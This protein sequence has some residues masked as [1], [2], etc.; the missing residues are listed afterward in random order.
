MKL[1][2]ICE[3]L[4]CPARVSNL[5]LADWDVLVRQ[6]RRAGLLARLAETL[7]GTEW[8]ERVPQPVRWHL[9][10]DH[11]LAERQKVAVRWEVSQIRE[12]LASLDT[13]VILLKGAAYVMADLPAARGR[14]FGD[15]DIL[16]PDEK[17]SQAEAALMLAGWHAQA[18]DAYDERYY[19]RWMHEIPP[20]V[21]L[22]RGSVVDMHH[23]ILPRTAR[24]HPDP[25]KLRAAALPLIGQ[26][27]LFVLQPTDMVLHA[28]C[29]LFHDGE[30]PHG[31]RDLS[32]MDILMRHFGHDQQFWAALPERAAEL[33]LTRP[34]FYAL[35]Y[36]RHFFGTP[37]PE[38]VDPALHKAAPRLVRLMDG[39]FLRALGPEHDS[40]QD[41]WSRPARL[42]AYIR[43]HWLRMPPLMLA[44][45]LLHKALISRKEPQA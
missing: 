44:W 42:A 18:Q 32:D 21:H 30:L 40:Y 7:T 37:V 36:V 26:P 31:L 35:R 15:I 25:R 34:L 12:A 19:R 14:L 8:E 1:P 17:I 5:A 20:M 6:A 41:V 43:A 9:Q 24:Y 23:A 3:T 22:K 16:V 33:E 28:A 11:I 39:M 2:L 4:S 13:S 29:H 27:G 45:H 10:A 38:T